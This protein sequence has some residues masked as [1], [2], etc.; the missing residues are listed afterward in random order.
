MMPSLLVL[1]LLLPA[2]V[3][4]PVSPAQTQDPPPSTC[5]PPPAPPTS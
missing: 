4:E 2:S 3:A 1:A 5:R